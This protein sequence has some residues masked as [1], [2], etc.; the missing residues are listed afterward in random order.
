MSY[1]KLMEDVLEIEK[2]DHFGRGI[3]KIDNIPV[4]VFNAVEEDEVKIKII[5]EKKNY[6][7]AIIKELIKPSNLRQVNPC[8]YHNCGGCSLL[9]INN[10][11]MIDYKSNRIKEIIT[12]FSGL[13]IK[14]N[15]LKY[16]N[17]YNYRNKITLHI[18][19]DKI[20]LYEIKSN[21][22]VDITS[23]LLVNE[24]IN[25]I[26]KRIS[27]FIK[28]N[29]HNLTEVMIRNYKNQ[30]LIRFKGEVDKN[31]LINDF[32][33]ITSL[34]L[35]NEL[36]IGKN[37]IE[38]D[39]LEYKFLVSK[40]SFFQVNIEVAEEMFS[41][42]RE[43]LKDK[44]Y[45]EALDLYCGTGVI[46]IILSK[47]I[48]HITGIE[49]VEEAIENANINKKINNVNNIDF[50]CGKTEDYISK[51]QDIDLIVVDP[52]RSG[53][54]KKTID[55]IKRIQPK[56]IIY[57]SCDAITLSR[58]L[59]LLNTDYNIKELT[60]FDMFPNTYHVECVSVLKLK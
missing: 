20:G 57:V 17:R 26:I 56:T 59:K 42:I 35:N 6:K 47:Y 16:K 50:V 52:P 43:Y 45:K 8:H 1:N 30:T 54:D 58:D 60:P 37:Q 18:K 38:L 25:D 22:I 19:D 5:K 4:F 7:E 9:N 53:L 15:D 12:K 36:L 32:K 31:L 27:Y 14:I 13:D 40:E 28:N 2:L 44:N 21:N 11:A 10:K 41:Y 46:G 33:D 39:L 24:A 34:W 51:F 49:L 55:N 23:C 3:T 48:N 29:H